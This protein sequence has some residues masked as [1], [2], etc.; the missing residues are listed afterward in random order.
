MSSLRKSVRINSPLPKDLAGTTTAR[1]LAFLPS[2][3]PLDLSL[4][5]SLPPSPLLIR[6]CNHAGE[7]KKASKIL[8]AFIGKDPDSQRSF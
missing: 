5:H 3:Q 6:V 4:T 2:L 7:C 1:D 8:N